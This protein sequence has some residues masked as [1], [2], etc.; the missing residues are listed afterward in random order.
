LD[1]TAYAQI[2]GHGIVECGL[3]GAGK[4]VLRSGIEWEPPRGSKR[5]KAP[6]QWVTPAR[7]VTAL[8]L[9]GRDQF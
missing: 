8:S 2:K 6:P 9:G 7:A 4:F 3:P 1:Q 5:V